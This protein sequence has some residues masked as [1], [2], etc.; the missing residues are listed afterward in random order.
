MQTTTQ[1]I[2][3]T[4]YTADLGA[5][6]DVTIYVHKDGARALGGKGRL[7]RGGIEDVAGLSDEAADALALALAEGVVRDC[8]KQDAAL[9]GEFPDEDRSDARAQVEGWE[10][11]SG[12]A[13]DLATANAIRYLG[14]DR[15]ARVYAE[16][17]A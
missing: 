8:A 4:T 11:N 10:R 9:A 3:G 6:G 1:T 15:A 7:T 13:G 17:A 2:D 16:A 12:P 14:T 5:D